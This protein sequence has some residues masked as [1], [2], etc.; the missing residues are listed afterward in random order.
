MSQ[1]QP[2][3]YD[4]II[5]AVFEQVRSRTPMTI[6]EAITIQIITAKEARTRIEEEGSV[7]RDTKG[8]VIPH[9]ALKIEADA[10]KLYTSLIGKYEK[11]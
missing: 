5:E 1:E 6:V 10:V 4:E 8:S 2:T 3:L 11:K 9:P 7:V